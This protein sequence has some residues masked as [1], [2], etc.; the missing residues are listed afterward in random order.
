MHGL[1][2]TKGEEVEGYVRLHEADLLDREGVGRVVSELRPYHVVHLAAVANV[3]HGDVDQMYQV[4]VLG[5]RTLLDALSRLP[6]KP[7]SVLIASS[8][9]IYGN[10]HEGV[11]SEESGPAPANDYGVSKFAM[12][13]VASLY[14]A[15]LPL[16]IARPFN[17]T[18]RGQSDAFII[19]KIVEH[20]REHAAVIELGNIDVARDFSD[21]RTIA[22][23]YMRLVTAPE[24]IGRTFNV[25]S[26]R[27]VSLREVLGLV[28][29]LSGHQFE[30]RV[31]PQFVRS[32][33]VRSLHGSPH[34]IE[35]VIGALRHVPLE[36]TL[37]WM[38]DA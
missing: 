8:A 1:V 26:G 19:P 29:G 38:L 7:E 23:A 16:I 6:D 30:V 20:A 3:A 25:C 17:Y 11:L 21:V 12:E 36:E 15:R 34:K 28:T 35:Q 33:E 2:Q 32:N 4:N 37:R 9:N 22:D 24:A 13:M 18:G 14:Q 27:A 10:A 5:S 31:N